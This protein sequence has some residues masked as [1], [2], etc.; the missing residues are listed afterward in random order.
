MN[1]RDLVIALAKRADIPYG[2]FSD[3]TQATGEMLLLCDWIA[4]ANRDIQTRNNRHW[5]FLHTEYSRDLRKSFKID[6]APAFNAGGGLVGIPITGHG[7]AVGDEITI[8]G[9]VNYDATYSIS[10][11]TADRVDVTKT[12]VAE[13]FAS[14]MDAFVSDYEFYTTDSVKKLTDSF[15]YYA[16]SDGA[17][18][19][20][21]LRL[22]DYVDFQR[23]YTDYTTSGAPSAITITP[24]NRIRLWPRLDDSYVVCASGF[25]KSR[26]LV[27][28]EDT[29]PFADEFHM[30]CVWKALIDYGGFEEASSV[31]VHA[32]ARY[33]ELLQQLTIQDQYLETDMV[34][35]VE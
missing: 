12:Y 14:G 10:A 33:E 1:Y 3:V 23:K 25:L 19:K 30:M 29:P 8:R 16:K 5:K 7:F 17:N 11:V 2:A 35:R 6:A 34:V 31:Y 9:T 26:E 24:N 22:V 21:K 27:E 18:R 15:Y 4:D 28:N 20:S 13:T 32:A